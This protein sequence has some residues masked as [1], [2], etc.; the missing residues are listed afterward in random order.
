MP[1]LFFPELSHLFS[2]TETNPYMAGFFSSFTSLLKCIFLDNQ[3]SYLI[4]LYHFIL[5]SFIEININMFRL[6][7]KINMFTYRK[8]FTSLNWL[9]HRIVEHLGGRGARNIPLLLTQQHIAQNE[10]SN[11]YCINVD[12]VDGQGMEYTICK[13]HSLNVRHL[14]GRVYI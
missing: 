5:F 4:I 11:S 14:T 8:I 13:H 10:H 2:L 3:Y 7:N 9:L 6:D 1:H 12:Y